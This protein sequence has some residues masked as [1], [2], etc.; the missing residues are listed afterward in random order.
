MQVVTRVANYAGSATLTDLSGSISPVSTGAFTAGVW[1]GQVT[2]T[3]AL[4]NDAITATVSSSSAAGQSGLF[5]V[6]PGALASFV[7]GAISSPQTAGAAFTVTITAQDA[8]GNTVTSY[9]GSATLTDLSG[10]ISPT[11]AVTFTAGVWTGLVTITKTQVNDVITATDSSSHDW[12]ERPV[13]G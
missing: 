1:T 12:A 13:H 8:S 5:T 11:S 2:I 7:F 9:A 6:N 10:S 3:K 4:T